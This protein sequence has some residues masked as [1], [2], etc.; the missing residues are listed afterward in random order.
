MS[1]NKVIIR[2]PFPHK[3]QKKELASSIELVWLPRVRI[4]VQ[5]NQ[6]GD[7]QSSSRYPS[8]L[9]STD[10][11]G[12]DI[13]L[14]MEHIFVNCFRFVSTVPSHTEGARITGCS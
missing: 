6:L 8:T 9:Q 13:L 4:M 14:T 2:Y 7:K 12:N 1:G 10:A 11:V 5:Q 3:Y